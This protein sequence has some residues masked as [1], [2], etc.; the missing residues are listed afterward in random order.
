MPFALQFGLQTGFVALSVLLFLV[1]LPA[2]VG[3]A[4]ASWR[5]GDRLV[6]MRLI[7]RWGG[8]LPAPLVTL[9]GA[10]LLYL[11]VQLPY[12]GVA[13]AG[14]SLAYALGAVVTAR[15]QPAGHE[16]PPSQT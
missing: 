7:A 15:L 11:L 1:A 9:L 8:Q 12:L 5:L 16:R 6:G 2:L 13:V 14:G 3:F 10:S 4:A